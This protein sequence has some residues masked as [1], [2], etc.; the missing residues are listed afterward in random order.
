MEDT[1]RG[2]F[3][4]KNEEAGS[5]L[6]EEHVTNYEDTTTAVTLVHHPDA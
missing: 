4:A 6:L 2:M 1:L 5:F 3:G